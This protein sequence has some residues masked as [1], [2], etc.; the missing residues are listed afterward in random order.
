MG[1][2][3]KKLATYVREIFGE[4]EWSY[5]QIEALREEDVSHRE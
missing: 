5:Q 1:G 4:G 3:G 2:G